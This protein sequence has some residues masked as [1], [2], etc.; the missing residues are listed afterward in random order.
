MMTNYLS[1]KICIFFDDNLRKNSRVFT[2]RSWM[3]NINY[4]N[5]FFNLL[6]ECKNKKQDD[7]AT[8]LNKLSLELDAM[9][10]H[11]LLKLLKQ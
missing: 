7:F 1:R 6:K 2:V 10:F 4:K 8:V 3:R 11:L 9:K 5:R